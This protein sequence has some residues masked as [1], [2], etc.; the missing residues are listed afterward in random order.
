MLANY[1]LG[2]RFST[3]ELRVVRK[4]EVPTPTYLSVSQLMWVYISEAWNSAQRSELISAVHLLDGKLQR[5]ETGLYL[6]VYFSFY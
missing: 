6:V 1:G 3:W 4:T 2:I 5:A